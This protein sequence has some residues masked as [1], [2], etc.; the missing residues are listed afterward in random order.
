MSNVFFT[1]R[2]LLAPVGLYMIAHTSKMMNQAP[3]W[4]LIIINLLVAFLLL[5]PQLRSQLIRRRLLVNTWFR[6]DSTI[7]HLIQGGV[8]YG[9][10]RFLLVLP[11]AMLLVAELQHISL[12][13][14]YIIIIITLFISGGKI[15]VERKLNRLV[16]KHPASILSR[17]WMVWTFIILTIPCWCYLVLHTSKANLQGLSLE[18]VITQMEV[19]GI[20]EGLFNS[21]QMLSVFKENLFWWLFLNLKTLLSNFP[22]WLFT[23]SHYTLLIVY[24]IYSVSIVYLLSRLIGGLLELS[25]PCF[26]VFFKD[27]IQ[28]YQ[29]QHLYAESLDVH[30]TSMDLPSP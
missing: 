18:Q 1:I 24:L 16:Y 12:I 20:E 26:Y 29:A 22:D 14:W 15:L 4:V 21:L 19:S 7:L 10:L 25:D 8:L 3:E 27:P 28:A 23:I 13:Q 30:D 9:S 6:Q 11:L 2:L 17:E 5:F